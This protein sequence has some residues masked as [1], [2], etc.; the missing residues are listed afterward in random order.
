[1]AATGHAPPVHSP[2]PASP[3]PPRF[4]SL[5]RSLL[6]AAIA[7]LL[8]ASLRAWWGWEVRRRIESVVADVRARGEPIRVEDYPT[9]PPGAR[10]DPQ[11]AAADL[12][13]AAGAVRHNTTNRPSDPVLPFKDADRGALARHVSENVEA[14]ARAEQALGKP[15]AAWGVGLR[16]PVI[17]MLLPEL[18]RQWDLNQVLAFASLDAFERGG[19]AARA[20]RLVRVMLRQSDALQSYSPFPTVYLASSRLGTTATD[21]LR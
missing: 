12:V 14:I 6:A 21:V 13:A 15:G 8:I 4:R 5:K 18:S 17:D 7:V 11:N 9:D 2:A 16:R 1:M 10:A 20:L 3:L 19:D